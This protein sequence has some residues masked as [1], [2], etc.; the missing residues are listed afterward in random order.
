[1]QVHIKSN[2]GEVL[3]N[4]ESA[5][6]KTN[7]VELRL[8][9]SVFVSD[10]EVHWPDVEITSIF[11]L[12]SKATPERIMS[13]VRESSLILDAERYK[14]K[15]DLNA[16]ILYA[17]RLS[18]CLNFISKPLATR[19]SV[20]VRMCSDIPLINITEPVFCFPHS[21]EFHKATTI[22]PPAQLVWMKDDSV[23][24]SVKIEVKIRNIEDPKTNLLWY[25]IDASTPDCCMVSLVLDS[26][27][28]RMWRTWASGIEAAKEACEN[29]K[30]RE[31]TELL[32]YLISHKKKSLVG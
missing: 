4:V 23:F 14:F 21:Y 30:N 17:V 28:Q 26:A 6:L 10:L 2:L 27:L 13:F 29:H 31:L 15:V 18:D 8:C 3:L 9:T 20:A 7:L 16:G 22:Q 32:Q 25:V 11:V 5:A 19:N 1:M 12:D 24:M